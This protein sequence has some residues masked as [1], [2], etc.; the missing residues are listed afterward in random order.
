MCFDLGNLG[1]GMVG[2]FGGVLVYGFEGGWL[3][4]FILVCVWKVCRM[5]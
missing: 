1:M 5:D 4:C 2:I 3:G